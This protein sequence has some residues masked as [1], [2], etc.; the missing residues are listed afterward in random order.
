[1]A[2]QTDCSVT[3]MGIRHRAVVSALAAGGGYAALGGTGSAVQQQP[4]ERDRS[5]GSDQ[6]GENPAGGVKYETVTERV[7][8]T[9]NGTENSSDSGY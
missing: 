2:S 6:P 8:E 5:E 3:E 9:T 1:M 7:D 4:R